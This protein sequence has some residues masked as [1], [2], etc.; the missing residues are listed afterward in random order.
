MN[1][2][3]KKEETSFFTGEGEKERILICYYSK[4]GGEKTVA[5]FRGKKSLKPRGA[6][7]KKR[8]RKSCASRIS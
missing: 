8:G 4:G 3:R 1:K 7:G 6:R 2:L 5:V